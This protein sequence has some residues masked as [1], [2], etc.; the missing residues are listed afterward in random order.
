MRPLELVIKNFLAYREV[1]RIPFE[2]IH[3]A[4]LTGANGAGKSSLLDAITWAL[5]GKARANDK[6]QLLHSGQKEMSV[7]LTFEQDER[8][9]QVQRVYLKS[10]KTGRT[11]AFLRV[12][13]HD[14]AQWLPISEHASV[15]DVDQEIAKRVGL[16]YETF[17]TSAFLQQGKAD[18]FTAQ[19]AG[20]R[21][22]ILA[23]IL[24]LA[25]WDDYEARAKAAVEKHRSLRADNEREIR[26]LDDELDQE[27]ELHRQEDE[28]RAQ[29]NEAHA[30][31]E[32]ADDAFRA[33]ASTDDQLVMAQRE[34]ETLDKSIAMLERDLE[35]ITRDVLRLEQ[36]QATYADLVAQREEIEQG[37]AA[38]QQTEAALAML[39]AREAQFRELERQYHTLEKKLA[40]E[41]AHL[42]TAA[43]ALAKQIDAAQADADQIAAVEAQIAQAQADYDAL[44]LKKA[45]HEAIRTELQTIA[46]QGAQTKTKNEQVEA[47]GKQLRSRL[48][49]LEASETALCPVCNEPLSAEKRAELITEYTDQIEV[50]RESY[51][52]NEQAVKAGEKQA[53]QLEKHLKDLESA[54]KRQEVL[55]K[56]LGTLTERLKAAQGASE[57]AEALRA[58]YAALHAQLDSEAFGE[59][60]RA[61]MAAC[62]RAAADLGYDA[63]EHAAL[64]EQLGNLQDFRLRAHDLA[65][66][67]EKLPD[68]DEQLTLKREQQDQKAAQRAEQRARLP[69]LDA[70]IADLKARAK[71][72]EALRAERD[73]RRATYDALNEQY[74][75]LKSQLAN[76][77][78]FRQRRQTLY[79]QTLHWQAEEALYDELRYAFSK[80]GVPAMLIEAA[81]PELEELANDLLARMTD[82]RMHLRFETQRGKKSGEGTIETLD[83]LIS[84]ELGQ[85]D[86]D[87]YSGGESFR[88]NF[89]LR[90]ALSQFLARRAG[91]QLRTLVMDEGF[92]SQDAAGRERLIEAINAVQDKFD[93]I[94]IVTHIEEL[95][96]AFPTH[97]EVRKAPNGGGS[98]II[99]H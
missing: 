61:E 47:E 95:R 78:R 16:D 58:E 90:V 7:T 93:L 96:D 62:E 44:A 37:E 43:Q 65:Q 18:A 89:A 49:F 3:V 19:T 21:K 55:T 35:V 31:F 33:L 22:E 17:V 73:Q 27:G 74:S 87:L 88:V 48:E 99:I 64:R 85:R 13:E 39:Q 91:A 52:Q 59:A 46:E 56:Q 8:T 2:G 32:R 40:A 42:T 77:D 30:A 57:R 76:L 6:D 79:E 97:I 24:G 15:R 69:E 28:L 75:Y 25:R 1:V 66:A 20:K 54:L 5:W 80:K 45:E 26:R 41:R 82:G 63:D 60:V 9:Y 83:I 68:L 38:R 94:L 92:G 14:S 81:I 98:S 4:C 70:Q 11:E 10:G 23:D 34:R 29:L 71:Q 86:Y 84:D 67:L 12:R 36:A 50:L 53:K 51:R 72:A